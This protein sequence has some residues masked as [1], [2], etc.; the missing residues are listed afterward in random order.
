LH[1]IATEVTAFENPRTSQPATAIRPGELLGSAGVKASHKHVDE[2]DPRVPWVLGNMGA[3]GILWEL[4]K[5]FS[6]I[7]IS[8]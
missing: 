7:I 6:V 3:M 2:I 5:Y 1:L 8:L 4:P